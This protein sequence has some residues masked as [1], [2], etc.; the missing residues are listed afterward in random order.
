MSGDDGNEHGSCC[1]TWLLGQPNQCMSCDV[2]VYGRLWLW[3]CMMYGYTLLYGFLLS[4]LRQEHVL[5]VTSCLLEL[6]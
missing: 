1:A 3:L 6:F 4:I 2:N 5:R